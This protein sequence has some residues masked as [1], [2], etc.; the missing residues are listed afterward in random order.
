MYK[1]ARGEWRWSYEAGNGRTIAVSSEGYV[2]RADC[3]R[4]IEIMKASFNSPVYKPA[5]V[6]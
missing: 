2:H 4:S 6:W 3:E 1:D 5:L